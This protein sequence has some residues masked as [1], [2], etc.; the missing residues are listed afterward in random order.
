MKPLC[1]WMIFQT[2]HKIALQDFAAGE[3]IRKYD[4]IIGYASRPI[5][6]GEW[7]HEH[8]EATGLGKSKEYTYDFDPQTT[9]MPGSSDETFMGYLRR[10]GSAVNPQL[11]CCNSNRLLCQWTFR[12]SVRD[13]KGKVSHDR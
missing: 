8:N 4:N 5:K 11:S 1:F 7:V 12:A 6:K 10:D 13:S 9:I 2:P 3:G